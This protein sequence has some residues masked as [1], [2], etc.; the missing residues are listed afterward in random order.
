MFYVSSTRFVYYYILRFIPF[1]HFSVVLLVV[2]FVVAI[3]IAVA[4]AAIIDLSCRPFKMEPVATS[5]PSL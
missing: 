3:V 1:T 5:L 2:A 4:V